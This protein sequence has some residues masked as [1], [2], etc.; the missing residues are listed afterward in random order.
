MGHDCEN[1]N[2]MTGQGPTKPPADLIWPTATAKTINGVGRLLE[3]M[4]AMPAVFPTKDNPQVRP[5]KIGIAADIHLRLSPREGM[6]E[7]AAH[8]IASDVLRRYT[9]SS[10]YRAAVATPGAWRYGLDA[11][12]VE[13]VSEE[14]A[15]FA[16]GVKAQ[17]SAAIEKET[18]AMKATGIKVTLPFP[19]DQLKPIGESVK[20]VDLTIDL[21]DG[22]PFTVPFS[23]K[24][25]RRAMRQV[26]ELRASGAEVIIVMQG[27]LVAN[28]KIEGAGLAVQVRAPKADAAG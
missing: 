4:E 24:N 11:D 12:P 18:I 8:A 21:G 3:L 16:R 28:H 10:E 17:S 14:H 25:Y 20:S 23:G 7:G 22:R 15:R 9:S 6:T 13:P 26:E 5:L 27:R 2:P 1:G 19:P